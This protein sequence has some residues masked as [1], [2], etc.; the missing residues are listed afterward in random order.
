MIGRFEKNF[1]KKERFKKRA[2]SFILRFKKKQLRKILSHQGMATIESIA[3]LS[4]F[5]VILGYQLGL[6]GAIHSGILNSIAA[7]T[8]AFETFRNRT[9]LTYYRE[10]VVLQKPDYYEQSQIRWHTVVKE[11]INP[12]S[13]LFH[14]SARPISTVFIGDQGMRVLGRQDEHNNIY[15]F[16]LKVRKIE[17]NPIWVMVGYGMCLNANCGD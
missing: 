10:N 13:S 6:F 5:V 8:F 2:Q 3:L 11:N 7:R 17:I 4:I 16:D 12:P 15:N 1:L 9:N 14:A